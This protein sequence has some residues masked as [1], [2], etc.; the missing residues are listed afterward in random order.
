MKEGVARD[1]G[2]HPGRRAS[3]VK[4]GVAF[5]CFVFVFPPFF[6]FCTFL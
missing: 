4:E 5:F 6:L 1:G 3:L 2:R